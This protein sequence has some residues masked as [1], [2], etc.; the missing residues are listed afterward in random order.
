MKPKLVPHAVAQIEAQIAAA[1]P[2]AELQES[3]FSDNEDLRTETETNIV[4]YPDNLTLKNMVFYL[5]VPTLC[6][7]LNY[8]RFVR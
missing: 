4:Q 7:E 5:M 6:Y 3:Q 1:I 2:S 8:P